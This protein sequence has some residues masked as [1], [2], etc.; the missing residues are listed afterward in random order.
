VNIG[1]NEVAAHYTPSRSDDIRFRMGD[2]VKI[3]VG[4]HVDGYPADTTVTVEVGTR[5]HTAL[6]EASRDALRVCIEMVAPGT[7]VS[8]LGGAIARTIRSAGFKPIQNLTGHS[9]EKHNLHAGLSIPNIETRDRAA[10]EEGMIL[11]IEPFATTGAGKV[12]GRGRGNIYRV[13]RER[14]VPQEAQEFFERV[15][16]SFGT[17]PFAGRWCDTIDGSAHQHL[18]KL[19]RLG[20]LMNYPVLTEAAGGVVSQAEHS[21]IVTRDGCRVIT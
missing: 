13:V 10:I 21:V 6:I 3:D 15:R 18:N 9:M 20:V 14:K 11:A 7:T 4:A 17:F 8:A 16:T 2:V 5:N 12:V 19:V 1:V